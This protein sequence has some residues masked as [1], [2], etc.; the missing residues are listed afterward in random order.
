MM[1]SFTFKVSTGTGA[2]NEQTVNA[3]E[4]TDNP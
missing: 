2:V 1:S 3:L 4:S